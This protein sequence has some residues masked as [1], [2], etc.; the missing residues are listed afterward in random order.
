MGDS[1]LDQVG[2]KDPWDVLVVC[3]AEHAGWADPIWSHMT[4]MELVAD[5]EWICIPGV[6]ATRLQRSERSAEK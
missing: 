1:V 3:S 5:E 4:P 2:S 6:A